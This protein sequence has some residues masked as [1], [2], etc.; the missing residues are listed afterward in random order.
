MK[1]SVV[2]NTACV[3]IYAILL[4]TNIAVSD[5]HWPQSVAAMSA[6]LISL[7]NS[8]RYTLVTMEFGGAPCGPGRHCAPVPPKAVRIRPQPRL[9]SPCYQPAL[10]HRRVPEPGPDEPQDAGAAVFRHRQPPRR[11]RQLL[12]AFKNADE[13]SE[14]LARELTVPLDETGLYTGV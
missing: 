14:A 9:L 12:G 5:S 7:E 3:V 4:T 2:S 6:V 8:G 1:V 11:V 10:I 13:E